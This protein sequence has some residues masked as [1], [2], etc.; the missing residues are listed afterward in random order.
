MPDKI[1]MVNDS[2]PVTL[3]GADSISTA[4][5]RSLCYIWR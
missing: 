4:K 1:C 3:D 2:E 5:S